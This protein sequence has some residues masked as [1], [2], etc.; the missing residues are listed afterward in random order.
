MILPKSRAAA[1]Q[2]KK[3]HGTIS[4]LLQACLLFLIIKKML[5]GE[6]HMQETGEM[7]GLPLARA[8]FRSCE[9]RLREA[10]PDI[11][12]AAAVGLVGEGSECFGCD[13]EFSRDHDWGPA[14]CIW[15][16]E[17]ELAAGASRLNAALA[18][19]PAS[20]AGYPSRMRPESRMGRVGPLAIEVFYARF[21][22][23]RRIPESRQEWRNIPEHALAACTNGEVF[24]DG[25]GDFSAWRHALLNYYPQDVWL[26]KLAARC[27]N[28]AQAGQYNLPRALRRGETVCAMLAVSRFV[29]AALGMLFLLNRRYMPFYKWAWHIGQGLPFM[30]ESSAQALKRIASTPLVHGGGET[31][32]REVEEL[33]AR[34][35]AA[36]REQGLSSEK[37]SWL[38]A[39]GPQLA[40]RISD[41]EIARLNLLED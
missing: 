36:L 18:E 38:W 4:F 5:H 14:F 34:F 9:A 30:G 6:H 27:M 19:L 17:A 29:E 2:Y 21:T 35:A 28:M 16:P 10:V 25:K 3:V 15:L 24:T 11:M 22:G 39:H 1:K 26:K 13:D 31:V 41:P 37:D 8:F 12:D 7:R 33:C 23:L 40:A 32:C 20:F